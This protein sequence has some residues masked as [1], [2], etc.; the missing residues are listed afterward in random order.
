MFQRVLISTDFKDGL[1]RLGC[2]VPSLVQA[3]VTEATFFH[4]VAV[5]TDRSVPK[6]DEDGM[7]AARKRFEESIQT[8]PEGVTVDIHVTCGRPSDNIIKQVES[9]KCEVLFLGTPTRSAL[10]EKLFGSTTAKLIER[11]SVPMIILRPQLISTYTTD[12]L[13]L[14]CRNLMHNLLIPYDGTKGSSEFLDTLKTQ[15]AKNPPPENHKYWLLWVI[16]EN[17]RR[18]LRGDNPLQEAQARLQQ[19]ANTLRELNVTVETVVKEGDPFEEIMNAADYYDIGAI[20]TS[21]RGIGGFLRW[22]VPSLT[23]E[24]LR[25]SW[26]PVLYFPKG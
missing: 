15:I 12:E 21:S 25:Q 18:E 8:V 16:D 4:N 9:S 10:S 1:Y 20:A 17:I 22:S 6:V 7:K 5:Q 14:R 23:R 3:G 24:I 2:V 26:H 13:S 19:A 11:T